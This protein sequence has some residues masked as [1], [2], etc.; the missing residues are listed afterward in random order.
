MNF[1]IAYQAVKI[2]GTWKVFALIKEIP[3]PKSK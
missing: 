1:L 3:A 2:L